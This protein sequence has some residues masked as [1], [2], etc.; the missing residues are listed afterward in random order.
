MAAVMTKAHVRF[1][2][3]CRRCFGHSRWLSVNGKQPDSDWREMLN[4]Y[5]FEVHRIAVDL[6]RAD[7]TE[8][9]RKF[10]PPLP[11]VEAYMRRADRAAS[12]SDTD[13]IRGYWRTAIVSAI[14]REGALMQLWPF[15]TKFAA[16]PEA[17][18]GEVFSKS[19]RILDELCAME[20]HAGKRTSDMDRKLAHDI[21]GLL[22]Q[23]KPFA[24][25][26]NSAPRETTKENVCSS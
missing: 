19:Q 24:L 2:N 5:P 6:M 4:K 26:A 14:E 11:E 17:Y 21:Q 10:V 8:G 16:I 9:R 1:W 3:A 23:F 22:S 18:R 12:R 20:R 13:Y 7:V 25:A 15:A